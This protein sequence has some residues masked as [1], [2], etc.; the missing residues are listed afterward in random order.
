MSANVHSAPSSEMGQ[1]SRSSAL[2]FEDS[3]SK[4]AAFLKQRL[5][6]VKIHY[7]EFLAE[8]T[9]LQG[10]GLL[11]E[12]ELWRRDRPQDLMHALF[13]GHLDGDDLNAISAFMS[14]HL[15]M[16]EMFPV[17]IDSSQA[18]DVDDDSDEDFE[19]IVDESAI[20]FL[21]RKE[22]ETL[23]RVLEFKRLGLWSR[24]SA[25]F[26]GD[27]KQRYSDT[28]PSLSS[29]APPPELTRPKD[30]LDYMFAEMRWLAEDF[31]KERHWKKVTAKKL[32]YAALKVYKE[33]AERS[34]KAEREE[35]AR[36]RK[37]CGLIARMV[38]DWWR[39]MDKI[40]QTKQKARLTARHQQAMSTHLGHVIET[41]ERYT[42]WLTEGMVGVKQ[43]PT[44]DQEA[45]D[46][47]TGKDE[48]T[49][50]AESP[51]ES[52]A[53][54][55]AE[56]EESTDDEETIAEEEEMARRDA[57]SKED[58]SSEVAALCAEAEVLIDDLLPPG[59]IEHLRRLTEAGGTATNQGADKVSSKGDAFPRR[60]RCHLDSRFNTA[61]VSFI[62]DGTLTEKAAYEKT[63]NDFKNNYDEIKDDDYGEDDDDGPSPGMSKE[64]SQ[65]EAEADMSI[66]ELLARYGLRPDQLTQWKDK[67][68]NL[69][70]TSSSTSNTRSDTDNGS[71]C[72]TSG[73]ESSLDAS[74]TFETDGDDGE[75]VE[76][77]GLKQLL[78]DDEKENLK[79]DP[80]M[81]D[82]P[83][84][85]AIADVAMSAQ[86]QGNT[87]ASVAEPVKTPFLLAGSL[88]EYQVVGL[89]WL[90]AI[91]QKRLNGILADEMG[92][93][94]TIQTIALLAYLACELGIW[95][96]HLIVVPNSV[97]LNWEVEF[98]KWCPGFKILTYFGSAKE[99]KAKRKG[100]TKTNAFHVCITSYR[101]AIQD[102]S[103]FKRKK[104][105]YLILDEAQNIKNFKSQRWQ[106]LLTFNSQRRLLLT[107]TPLQNSLMELWSLMHFL[108]PNIFQS[109]REFQEW[110]ASPLTG[111]IEG[112]SEY[113]EQLVMRLHKVLRPFLL[114]RLKEDVERQMPKK[115]EHVILCRLSKRQRYLYDDFMS[116]STTKDTLASGQFLS[117][118]NILM[119][120]R[121]V[122]NHPNLF[123]P[124]PIT[125]P[126]RVADDEVRLEVP[127]L[128]AQASQP[129]LV[130]F[131]PTTP[132]A[133]TQAQSLD[134]LDRAGSAA[135]L[136]GQTA[137]L[138]EM[139]RD[140]P[141][142]VARRVHQ[143]QAKPGLISI[144]ETS[145]PIDFVSRQ[146][147]FFSDLKK[148]KGLDMDDSSG[149]RCQPPIFLSRSVVLEVNEE[150][151]KLADGHHLSGVKP[152]YPN[153]PRPV[154]KG[155]S[156]ILAH[157][158][159]NPWDAGIPKSVLRSRHIERQHRLSLLTRV[160]ERRCANPYDI[161]TFETTSMPTSDLVYFLTSAIIR[162][163]VKT[164]NRFA[165]GAWI[166][167]QSALRTWPDKRA[168][169]DSDG[170]PTY[171]R[172]PT[173]VVSG[174]GSSGLQVSELERLQAFYG[175]E[176][177]FPVRMGYP[178]ALRQLLFSS[179]DCLEYFS[180]YF[181]KFLI[182]TPSAIS[183]GV[184]L[185]TSCADVH[186]TEMQQEKVVE[187]ILQ[188]FL[189]AARVFKHC[190]VQRRS[191]TLVKLH[192]ACN[193]LTFRSWLMPAQLHRVCNS[194]LFQFPDPRLI[195]YDCGKL[196][197]LDLLLRELYADEHRV[198]IFTQMARMLDIL[199]QFLAYHG[200]RYLR[201]D[202]ATKV[203]QRQ[204][205]MERFNMD[206]RIFVFIL[207]TRSGGLGVNLTGADTVIFYDSDWNPTMDAQAQ[208]RCHRIGQTRDVH[209]YR[210]ISERTVEEN[211][212]RKANQKRLLSDVA[213][214]GGKFTTAFFKQS[215][216]S[217]LF[218]EPSGLMVYIASLNDYPFLLLDLLQDKEEREA[219]KAN[220]T[221][222]VEAKI[223][224]KSGA[225]SPPS[226]PLLVT[227][228]GRQIRW[229]GAT[230]ILLNAKLQSSTAA[231]DSN[232]AA[233]TD[234]QWVAALDA[235]EDD[236]ND[237]AAAKR[238]L[239][240]VK[241]DLEEFDES[242]PIE[243][244]TS[245]DGDVKASGTDDAALSIEGSTSDP[246]ARF[247]KKRQ[248]EANAA[249][250]NEFVVSD[251]LTPEAMVERELAEFES[252]LRPIERFGV[253]H[254][255]SFQDDTLNLELEQFEAQIEES[256]KE[257]KL[258]TLKALHEADEE[259]AELEEDE[260]LY[261]D[262]DYDPEAARLA[263]LDELERAE[264]MEEMIGRGMRGRRCR[265]GGHFRG[266]GPRIRGGATSIGRGASR[267][268]D[269]ERSTI[270]SRDS[271]ASSSTTTQF[272][273]HQPSDNEEASVDRAAW[274]HARYREN[275]GG[276]RRLAIPDYV[277]WDEEEEEDEPEA[278]DIWSPS[279]VSSRRDFSIA[280]AFATAP[281]PKRGRGRGRGRGTGIGSGIS[282][283]GRRRLPDYWRRDG[284]EVVP[285]K[286]RRRFSSSLYADD[287]EDSAS[288]SVR[289]DSMISV[290]NYSVGARQRGRPPTIFQPSGRLDSESVRHSDRITP[291]IIRS[292]NP[293]HYCRQYD[294]TYTLPSS[295]FS[296]SSS[297]GSTGVPSRGLHQQQVSPTGMLQHNSKVLNSLMQTAVEPRSETSIFK[298][299]PLPSR[300][301]EVLS[302]YQ[303]ISTQYHPRVRCHTP[304]HRL[305]LNPQPRVQSF[306]R[307][308][309][310]IPM[311][312]ANIAPPRQYH[313]SSFSQTQCIQEEPTV[314]VQ[315]LSNGAH[316]VQPLRQV[317][318]GS[319]SRPV[320]VITRQLKTPSGE[321]YQQRITQPVQPPT[322]Y[323]QVVRRVSQASAAVESQLAM[324]S[325]PRPVI[326][327]SSP[328]TGVT[329]VSTSATANTTINT[330]TATNTPSTAVLPGRKIIRVVRSTAPNAIR[331]L[332]PRIPP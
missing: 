140:L 270:Q 253:N 281:P 216:I 161:P 13:S 149:R 35:A 287:V 144:V 271:D 302:R 225:Q 175:P 48:K 217:D 31:K 148:R 212:L 2:T 215:I 106:T 235:C 131:H 258:N 233:I 63:K 32:A 194:H 255:E 45:S 330:S 136:L 220:K 172:H 312:S 219:A 17:H 238:A 261:C 130:A 60:K 69:E 168:C 262:P 85:K 114:R 57:G 84:L 206:S 180:T 42:M 263:E 163:P 3:R 108:M 310:G 24:D 47:E 239:D 9:Y 132:S 115:Y 67:K 184:R 11:T 275:T 50:N 37:Q 198:L 102:S 237:R 29:L 95:G 143:L 121:K 189:E 279:P 96:P 265:G 52:D 201:L 62:D 41:T 61:A 53:D 203:E 228:S 103:A 6:R 127:R 94:K 251:A 21:V 38:R 269:N 221:A 298:Q 14:G 112:N 18:D 240:E 117:V 294:A 291:S 22:V 266:R 226:P 242:K 157:C 316:S 171:L 68:N 272:R 317:L 257:W 19:R 73:D 321:I 249:D 99:R 155:A 256:K 187:D 260:I 173:C 304:R 98:K 259:R 280:S 141:A 250:S 87:L 178:Q 205:L 151:G 43:Q 229:K 119:Q 274:F 241:A 25:S 90:V 7:H 124:R 113:N 160:N 20:P 183:S 188:P 23:K 308:T 89:S 111:M 154:L 179:A 320:F 293:R 133:W 177:A 104:W 305:M 227:R 181:E 65:L 75:T 152:P 129:F 301:E 211:I 318:S 309:V 182:T 252:L 153:L 191:S 231:S 197:R 245:G 125:S 109:H 70:S 209:I 232:Q 297:S 74:S 30:H 44:I 164:P 100:W 128:V 59:Y 170:P 230:S 286:R 268:I 243:G 135:R 142:F 110:F 54:F 10:G 146:R 300:E 55:V 8:L 81:P 199:E 5:A 277:D 306:F 162:R 207:S 159:P 332:P 123:E 83:E 267:R 283:R 16:H 66:E 284:S 289:S 76:E 202:G 134:W 145:D 204:I 97:I 91:Y 122:C 319:S 167:C 51:K 49:E 193:S 314:S 328:L 150:I 92:L 244:A 303:P 64:V 58:G 118:M 93:G 276:R 138:A 246:L 223:M 139:A 329:S 12:F 285:V 33:K 273:L 331:I 36:I 101:L 40:V 158:R 82:N 290:D 248:Q 79:D 296:Y 282:T 213:I 222:D 200:Y 313:P 165:T 326:R 264:E 208:D 325:A 126:F 218:A 26:S 192:C 147:E 120:L 236:E 27:D 46:R 295:N 78:S 116:L 39:Q 292:S 176:A 56:E 196:Q 307:P 156:Y 4:V 185:H 174:L 88:R 15:P 214:E 288:T 311:R 72:E 34:L 315:T 105:K 1:T 247:A 323:V 137:T 299:P 210:L 71:N 80:S 186:R 224:E 107:G 278:T 324:P 169:D 86:P 254:L 28:K 195:Q 166:A 322:K 234:S 190:S 327:L 77:L